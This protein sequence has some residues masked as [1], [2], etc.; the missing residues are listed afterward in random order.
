MYQ[1]LPPDLPA[2]VVNTTVHMA[3]PLNPHEDSHPL[4][5]WQEPFYLPLGSAKPIPKPPNLAHHYLLQNQPPTSSTTYPHLDPTTFT[6]HTSTTTIT[7]PNTHTTFT[8]MAPENPACYK[9]GQTDHV[10]SNR[11]CPRP[12]KAP[13][14]PG[15]RSRSSSVA[16]LAAIPAAG[17]TLRDARE[18][19]P[20]RF[21]YWEEDSESEDED[22]RGGSQVQNL[23]D[24][25]NGNDDETMSDPAMRKTVG[26]DKA[27]SVRE[28][29]A[30][31][32]DSTSKADHAKS[33]SVSGQKKNAQK[34]NAADGKS[35]SAA[36]RK[37]SITKDA[38]IMKRKPGRPKK[39][40]TTLNE[41]NTT[42]K[43]VKK[44]GINSDGETAQNVGERTTTNEPGI[45][46]IDSPKRSFGNDKNYAS[47]SSSGLSALDSDMDVDH[48]YG[49][50]KS[51]NKT[52][53]AV[54][55]SKQKQKRKAL[56]VLSKH[57]KRGKEA[58]TNEKEG[59]N[60]RS[61]NSN[62]VLTPEYA[63]WLDRPEND[64]LRNWRG[65]GAEHAFE[66]VGSRNRTLGPGRIRYQRGV[67]GWRD[68]RSEGGGLGHPFPGGPY[69]GTW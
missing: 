48:A 32:V 67:Q 29:E 39:K 21:W 6:L 14:A 12:R 8:D 15:P 68:S 51:P 46:R 53:E 59:P 37:K 43:A 25:M 56:P 9:C 1:K 41:K 69:T 61:K 55:S 40:A 27:T 52:P 42:E 26:L 13:G 36:G 58:D 18:G 49:T 19:D 64:P 20:T 22:E 28:G 38:S 60:K 4:T 10:A 54:E 45:A 65:T 47:D 31:K 34:A 16:A 33:K 23:I 35:N 7:T 17:K 50:T 44:S 66:Y 30:N 62:L 63:E 57:S 24:A 11:N 2:T 5:H 3:N